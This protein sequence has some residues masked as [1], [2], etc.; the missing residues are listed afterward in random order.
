MI[1]PYQFSSPMT[2]MPQQF[3]PDL[4]VIYSGNNEFIEKRIYTEA[5]S[6]QKPLNSIMNGSYLIRRMKGSSLGRRLWPDNTLLPEERQH[7]A[8]EQWLKIEQL[9]L[10]LRKNPRQYEKVREHYEFSIHLW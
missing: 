8:Y 5:G 9:A 10:D 4:V 3:E 6:W 7:I 1:I 2:L